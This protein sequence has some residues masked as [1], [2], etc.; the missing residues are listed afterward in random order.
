MDIYIVDANLIFSSILNLK[1]GISNFIQ[2]KEE[3]GIDFYAPEILKVEIS[4]HH[5]VPVQSSLR[6]SCTGT[7]RGQAPCSALRS[8]RSHN[9]EQGISEIQKKSTLRVKFFPNFTYPRPDLLR[10]GR[11]SDA[12]VVYARDHIYN[13]I[14]FID[15]DVIPFEEYIKAMRI[16]RDIDPDDVNFVALNNYL[17]KVLWTGD[18][19]L[20]R[21]L[22]EKG[23]DKVV[24]FEDLKKMYNV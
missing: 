18:L 13:F 16:V 3:Y 9:T 24:I 23:Y 4:N 10:A 17:N 11:L 21:G 8:L 15:D 5:S 19:K 20:Y 6:S 2:N 7:G 14:T 12:E 1:S 22:K